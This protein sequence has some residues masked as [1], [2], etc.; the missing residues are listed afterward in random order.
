MKRMEELYHYVDAHREVFI[1]ALKPLLRKQSI[2][3]TASVEEMTDCAQLLLKM[4]REQGF[5]SELYP[6]PGFP[7]VYGERIYSES[8]PT[9]LIYGH[10]DVMPVEPV[11]AWKTPPFEPTIVDEKIFCR[12]ASDDK[13]QSM[14]YMLGYQVYRQLFGDVPVNVKFIFDGEEEIGSP[15]LP[16]FVKAHRE[17]LKADF[18]LSSDSKIHESGR[19]VL[20]LGLKGMCSVDLTVKGGGKDLHS[21]YA[22]V[23]PSPVWRLVTLLSTLKGEDGLVKLDR[24]YDDVEPLTQLDREAV[25]RIPFDP[26]VMKKNLDID[27]FIPNRAGENFYYNYIFEP[28]CNIGYIGAGYAD[29]VKD[30]I[31][32]EATVR[33]DL[34]L[35]PRQTPE[36]VLQLL[37]EHLDKRGYKDVTITPCS[38]MTPY[39]SPLDAPCLP[40]L[41]DAVREVW[42][43]EPVILPGIGGFGPNSNFSEQLGIPN[44][45]IPYGALDNSNHAP[46][47]S[48]VIDGYLKGIKVFATILKK[49]SEQATNP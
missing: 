9:V 21:M 31:P 22:P 10:Y 3:Y 2:S 26:E 25:D 41:C 48:L 35:V 23:A 34:N 16:A 38:M 33:L 40:L 1:E 5:T 11:S 6:S 28:T 49:L 39:R 46:N 24:F 7:Y 32:H 29:G 20:F 47:E 4:L 18:L 30:V 12:G 45:Y 8:A 13:G 44:I 27:R 43:K 42:E 19:P 36:K 15:N 17:M 37:R 14:T